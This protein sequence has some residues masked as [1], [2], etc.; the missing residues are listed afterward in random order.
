M[1]IIDSEGACEMSLKDQCS[2]ER[3]L[4]QE[5]LALLSSSSGRLKQAVTFNKG[6]AGVLTKDYGACIV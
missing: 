4:R 1:E 3:P 2:S 5:F 6:V